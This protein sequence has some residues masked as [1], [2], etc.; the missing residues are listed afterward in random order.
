L[1][2]Q[3]SYDASANLTAA[4]CC[5]IL[6]VCLLPATSGSQRNSAKTQIPALGNL[7]QR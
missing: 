4:G 6:L 1:I 2:I 3:Q 7:Y 5:H